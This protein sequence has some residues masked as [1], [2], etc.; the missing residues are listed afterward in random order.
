M[1]DLGKDEISSPHFWVLFS[2]HHQIRICL[3]LCL[4]RFEESSP[5]RRAV[6]LCVGDG[7]GTCIEK[8][9]FPLPP[10]TSASIIGLEHSI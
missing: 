2:L 6:R 3:F 1:H 5:S 8:C 10:A 7:T 9:S 4:F